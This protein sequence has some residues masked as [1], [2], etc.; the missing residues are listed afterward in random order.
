MLRKLQAANFDKVYEIMEEAFPSDERRS[1]GE[2]KA[3]LSKPEYAVYVSTNPESEELEAFI[4]LY[5]FDGFAFIEHF[6]TNGAYRNRGIGSSV[7]N[8]LS[9]LLKCR[10]CL[11]AEMPETELARRRIGFYKR[12]GFYV[13]DFEYVQPPISKGKMPIPMIV[14]SSEA[15]LS[16]SEFASIKKSVYKNVYGINDMTV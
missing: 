13:N 16:K 1:Y 7:L 11:E 3:L 6:A 12:N 2:Q 8:E 9:A 14:M 4:A 5:R 10:M 15:P